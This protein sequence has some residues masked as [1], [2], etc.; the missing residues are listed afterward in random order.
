[1]K[2]QRINFL[3]LS[4]ILTLSAPFLIGCNEPEIHSEW[5]NGEITVDGRD[6]EWRE[7]TQHYD[8][9][10]R[11]L[12]SM[13]NDEDY[14]YICLS[15]RQP[16]T[17]QQVL[18]AGLTAWFEQ[19]AGKKKRFG[20]HFPVGVMR[21]KRMSLLR[22]GSGKGPDPLRQLL[23]KSQTEIQ[24]LGP[25]ENEQITMAASHIRRFDIDVRIG[26]SDGN[27]VYEL[28]VPIA[29]N[30]ETKYAVLAHL[31]EGVRTG[32][33]TE[34]MEKEGTPSGKGK[35]PPGGMSGGPPGGMRGGPSGGMSGGP[36]E[37][38]G[39][40]DGQMPE[41]FELWTKVKLASNPSETRDKEL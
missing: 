36:G 29:K 25:G 40:H 24:L 23:E 30:E 33:E 13:V 15:S 18:V 16:E 22:P 41:P 37:M 38:G 8:K 31:K 17:Q 21:E 9:D 6:I 12:I 28:K 32:F 34:N 5:R 4:L 3:L 27:L 19:K 20:V 7:Y 1:M 26:E 11:S 35:G 2:L 14:L 39:R 10:T